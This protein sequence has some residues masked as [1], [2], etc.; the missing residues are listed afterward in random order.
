MWAGLSD[1]LVMNGRWQNNSL[2]LLSQDIKGC[3]SL[4]SFLDHCS[5]EAMSWGHSVSPAKRSMWWGTGPSANVHVSRSSWK[6]VLQPQ[7]DPQRLSAS[8]LN[9]ASWNTLSQSHR[10]AALSNSCPQRLWERCFL[11][12]PLGLELISY[13]PMDNKYK[14]GNY[15][16]QSLSSI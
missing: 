7:P 8:I 12:T 13:T 15:Y 11:F 10:A 16:C 14:I 3:S 5:G 6:W 4:L 2:R 9:A 1:S